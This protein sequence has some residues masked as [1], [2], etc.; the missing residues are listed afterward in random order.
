MFGL[1]TITHWQFAKAIAL[2]L[3]GY[4]VIVLLYLALKKASRKSAVSFELEVLKAKDN[5]QT[6]EVKAID[7]PNEVICHEQSS[8]SEL[9]TSLDDSP[10][11][12]GYEIDA[13]Q[14]T[15]MGDKET[16]LNSIEY[17]LQED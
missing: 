6:K 3:I 17:Q 13:L 9:H 8:S 15:Q 16:F 1:E 12:S 2:C 4:Y 5:I 11:Y 7:F 10:D 14:N